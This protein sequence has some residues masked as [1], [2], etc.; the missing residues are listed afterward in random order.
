MFQDIMTAVTGILIL[1]VI[2]QII[3]VTAAPSKESESKAATTAQYA[4]LQQALKALGEAEAEDTIL[5]EKLQE[6]DQQNKMETSAV[7]SLEIAGE[8]ARDKEELEKLQ[9]DVTKEKQAEQGRDASV[10]LAQDEKNLESSEQQTKTAQERL[11]AIQQ[12]TK[13][14]QKEI[15][16]LEIKLKMLKN[17]RSAST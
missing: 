15:Q 1:I 2:L 6:S 17:C 5:R 14:N 12:E 8:I 7:S 13:S 10:G 16:S 4:E 3:Q 11:V 9:S